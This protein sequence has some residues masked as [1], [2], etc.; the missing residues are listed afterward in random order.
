MRALRDG[1]G[2]HGTLKEKKRV[3]ELPLHFTQLHATPFRLSLLVEKKAHQI[4]ANQ[5]MRLEIDEILFWFHRNSLF[6]IGQ[7][8]ESHIHTGRSV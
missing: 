7:Q 5:T 3:T 4:P 1:C 2:Y 8:K 6:L